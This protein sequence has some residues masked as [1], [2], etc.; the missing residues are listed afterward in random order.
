M[1]KIDPRNKKDIMAV[2]KERAASY[3]P[4]WNIDPDDPDIGAAL[5]IACAEMFEGTIK[6]INGL[7]LKNQIAF[8]NMLNAS[9]L[10]ATP[11]EGYV[12]FALSASDAA[13]SEIPEG[14]VVSSYGG[15]GEPVH[16]E[17]C[18]DILVSPAVIEKCFCVDDEY[19]HIGSYGDITSCG[20]ELFRLPD[21]NLQSHILKVAHP[22]A[23]NVRSL[24]DIAVSFFHRGGI[25]LRSSDIRMFADNKAAKIEYYTEDKGYIP[26][27]E[28]RER[29]GRLI[30]TKGA[31]Q[32]PVSADEDGSQ[33]RITVSD[34]KAFDKFRYVFAE[35][36]PSG[37]QIL[38][39]SIT[40]G[41][42]EL[43]I[44][45][46]FP[47][48]DRFQLYNEVY[49][50]CGE[51]LDKRGA[52][53]TMNF[54]L[55]F[56][57]VP[58]ENQLLD[59][60]IKWKWIAKKSDF[61][62]RTSYK[63][64]ITNVM[65]EY[66]NGY[67]WSRLFPDSS[68]S[69]IFN[70]TEGVT[71]CFRSITFVCPED[72]SEV[73]VG[74]REDYYI[75]ARVISGENLYKLKGDFMS[76][77]IRNISFDY[78]YPYSGCRI[79]QMTAFNC[80]EEKSFDPRAE[81][82]FIPFYGTGSEKRTIYLG[83][84]YSPENGPLRTLW[85]IGED[86]DAERHE[87]S[88]EYF[89]GAGWRNMN[90]VDETKGFTTVG[91]TI[92]LDNHDFVRKKLFG[93]ELYWIRITDQNK[94][95]STGA[96]DFPRIKGIYSNTVR[97]V[98]VD[99]HKEEY[100][101]M[102]VY[103]ENASFDLSSESILDIEVFVN[104]FYTITEAET[105]SLLKQGRLRRV[106]DDAG[107]TTGIW[108]R[109]NR[110]DTFA[111]ENNAS[112]CYIADK[113]AGRIT[114]GNGRR[115]RIPSA[116][117]TDNIYVVYTTGG[118]ER[119]NAARGEISGMERSIGLISSVSN[120]KHFYGGS[121]TETIYKALRRNSV[122]LKT[123]GKAVTARDLEELAMYASNCVKKV[124]VFSGR[125]IEG[126]S[127]RGTVTLVVLKKK[128]AQFSRIRSEMKKYL[129]PRLPGIITSSDSLCITEPSFIR[130][131]IK[132]ELAADTL[133]GIFELKRSVERSLRECLDSY[134]GGEDSGE[135]MLGKLPNEHQLR[136]AILRIRHITYIRSIYV[137][138]YLDSR[139]GLTELDADAV[140][141]L[142][143]ILPV[144]GVNDIS[145]VQA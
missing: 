62:E 98:N 51:V 63:L 12:S 118:G 127:E 10:P 100:F 142:P 53:I 122:M 20:A 19:D 36:S 65:W 60:E 123:Q 25:P 33:L 1:A 55:S 140:H 17:T 126:E 99:S 40:D 61:K 86:P 45:A 114:F 96:A 71:N 2:I 93:E 109:W 43:E 83:Y 70:F 138:M 34:I 35:A 11:S 30:L 46:F 78:R 139:G 32:P 7:P 23:F 57:Q 102:N 68:Y 72:M 95:Y 31:K 94:S 89:S 37:R 108:V 87:L 44:N 90:M 144:S 52:E 120:P 5:A 67:G 97:A 110:V 38:P 28:V 76:P 47:F 135:W 69:D 13:S 119:S 8:Y 79:E 124:R 129:L 77:F 82:E 6:K 75:R 26:F 136:S 112:R 133:S 22:Y 134:S 41:D 105:E 92:F 125:N 107:I 91:L 49:F 128:D 80:F 56:L 54:D 3:T 24:T 29:D 66:Y 106:T 121:D 64:S 4:E 145:I 42:K 130:M 101:A 117:D 21:K 116:S 104:E 58:I 103:S 81:G 9:L 84:S 111:D 39:D 132:A 27:E 141:R 131:D 115:G 88:W 14:Y 113:S 50:G 18:D 59:E 143:Y 73:F 48:G 74:A 16:F 15:D 85:D 137:T